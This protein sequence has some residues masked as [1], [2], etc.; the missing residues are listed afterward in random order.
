MSAARESADAAAADLT[1]SRASADQILAARARAG[2]TS[3]GTP[4]AQGLRGAIAEAAERAGMELQ[5]IEEQA[6]RRLGA[7]GSLERPTRL[8]TEDVTMPDLITFLHSLTESMPR[9]A[10]VEVRLTAPQGA[11]SDDEWAAEAT[12]SVVE[13]P[14]ADP[15]RTAG[16]ST[17]R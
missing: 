11:R 3:A 2:A 17:L 7:G 16:S 8:R 15:T 1:G 5:S 13:A 4:D 6:P 12:L 14:P 10:V 9:L